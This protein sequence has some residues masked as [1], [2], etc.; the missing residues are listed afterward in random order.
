MTVSRS[1]RQTADPKMKSAFRECAPAKVNLALHVTG[2]R[3]DGYHLLDSLVVFAG[4]GD[5]IEAELAPGLSLSIGGPFGGELS[6]GADN[7]VLCAARL[8]CG[9]DL[10]AALRLTKTLP[11]ASGIGG[12][13]SDAAATLRLLGRLWD[14]SL[15]E[16]TAVLSLG[17]DV[18]VCLASRPARMSGIGEIV[19]PVAMPSF[20]MVLVNPG[21]PVPTGAIFAGLASRDNPAM[22]DLPV[23]DEVETLFRFVA[24]QRNDLEAPAVAVAPMVAEVLTALGAQPGCAV[25]RMSGSGA[26]CFG[27]FA[28][29]P[30]ALAAAERISYARPAWWA[31]ATRAG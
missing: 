11:V 28:G 4:V 21:V 10:G 3:A 9:A 5:C 8:L 26:T 18:P 15:P 12:G 13:S 14:V 7:L 6:A 27:L 16:A 22:R 17:A 25:A 19:T 24:A 30:A 2:R 31:V 20:W 29:E 23:F 1:R